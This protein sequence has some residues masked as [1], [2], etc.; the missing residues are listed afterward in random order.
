M[1]AVLLDFIP[2]KFAVNIK[3]VDKNAFVCSYTQSTGADLYAA[4]SDNVSKKED[5]YFESL[6]GN[7]PYKYL[8]K[9]YTA[10]YIEPSGN[11]YVLYSTQKTD[12]YDELNV[13]KWDIKYPVLRKSMRS[14]YAPRAYLTI[15]DFDLVKVLKSF[16]I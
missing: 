16:L 5:V 1:F 10:D 3:E 14:V 8:S 11:R 15:Y 7:L 13:K 9:E 2:V 4:K 12:N 6:S